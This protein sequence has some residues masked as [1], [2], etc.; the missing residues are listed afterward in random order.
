[1]NRRRFLK[2]PLIL[3]AIACAPV[4]AQQDIPADNIV[5]TVKRMH[6]DAQ[7]F[8]NVRADGF[9]AA[10][11][12]QVWQVLTDYERLPAFVPNLSSSR[13]TARAG[14]EIVLEQHG[15]TG[16]LFITRDVHL[17]VRVA[18]QPFTAID[19]ALVEGDMKHYTAHWDLV[20]STQ[21]GV[22]GTLMRYSATLEPD[23]FVPP[24]LGGPLVQADVKRTMTAVIAEIGKRL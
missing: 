2:Y 20:P 23:F 3:L 21:H 5:I 24:L 13:V 18:E 17:V 1:M 4:H 8:F 11:P 14:H 12:K 9:A 22:S 7:S 15:K 6:K 19:I 16:F 10:T